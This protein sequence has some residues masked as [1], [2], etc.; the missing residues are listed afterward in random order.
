MRRLPCPRHLAT[1]HLVLKTLV[2]NLLYVVYHTIRNI[3]LSNCSASCTSHAPY[4]NEAPKRRRPSPTANGY[5]IDLC[6]TGLFECAP[7]LFSL[8]LGYSAT[9]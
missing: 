5:G 3:S 7:V 2:H 9:I 6:G 4:T 8:V 1:W